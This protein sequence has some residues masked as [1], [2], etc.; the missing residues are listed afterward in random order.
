[1]FTFSRQLGLMVLL[2]VNIRSI[3]KKFGA[4]LLL[5]L[6]IFVADYERPLSKSKKMYKKQYF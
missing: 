6:P 1:M 4:I 5:H 2:T 3:Q